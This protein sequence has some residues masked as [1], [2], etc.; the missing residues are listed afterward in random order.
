MDGGL[1]PETDY[2]TTAHARAYFDKSAKAAQTPALADR[3]AYM[4]ARCEANAF[5]LQRSI[6]Q[7]RNGYVYE[8]DSAFVKKMVALRKTKYAQFYTD[9]Y[10]NHRQSAFNQ[11]MIRECALYKDFLSFGEQTDE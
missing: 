1:E 7:V 8:G 9:F 6:E 11:T 10:R 5:T 2:Y 4:T 3:S